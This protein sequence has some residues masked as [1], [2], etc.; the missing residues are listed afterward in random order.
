MPEGVW[1]VGEDVEPG[2]YASQDHSLNSRC[3]WVRLRGF[4]GLNDD[5]IASGR[6]VGRQIVEI[7]PSDVGFETRGCEE[8]VPLADAASPAATEYYNW[9]DGT[10]LVEEEVKLG[11]Y[12]NVDSIYCRWER[13]R[14]F[15]GEDSDIIADGR[16]HDQVILIIESTDGGGQINLLRALD[17]FEGSDHTCG[18]ND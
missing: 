6:S 9:G 12:I 17:L 3:H 16:E 18:H 15:S 1:V 4:S 11:V 7:K 10:W 8:W 5:T 2:I 13:L 14:G